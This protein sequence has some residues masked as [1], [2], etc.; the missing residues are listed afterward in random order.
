VHRK[1]AEIQ[2]DRDGIARWLKSTNAV[3]FDSRTNAERARTSD[4]DFDRVMYNLWLEENDES[5]PLDAQIGA[6]RMELEKAAAATG[7]PSLMALHYSLGPLR[8]ALET[9][10]HSEQTADVRPLVADIRDFIKEKAADAG[11]QLERA[12]AEIEKLIPEGAPPMSV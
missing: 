6:V 11:G 4:W 10:P 2:Q 8:K 3:P 1:T 5:F 7:T 9:Q 12:L